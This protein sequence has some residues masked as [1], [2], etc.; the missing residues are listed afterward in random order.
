MADKKGGY[1]ENTPFEGDAEEREA[2]RAID[3]E[4]ALC[5]QC[6]HLVGLDEEQVPVAGGRVIHEHCYNA[7]LGFGRSGS[8]SGPG[9]GST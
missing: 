6:N 4:A 1:S 7:Y 3:G 8:S 9:A 2:I 5:V